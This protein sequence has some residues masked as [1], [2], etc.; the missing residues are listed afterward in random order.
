MSNPS[1]TNELHDE[2][3]D[4]GDKGN[5]TMTKTSTDDPKVSEK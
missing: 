4:V 5:M 1:I 3:D 2:A